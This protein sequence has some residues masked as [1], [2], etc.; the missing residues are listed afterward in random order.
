M[1]YWAVQILGRKGGDDSEGYELHLTATS[2]PTRELAIERM[3]LELKETKRDLMA[4]GNGSWNFI[5]E[6]REVAVEAH[7]LIIE[8]NE[9][10][11]HA[12]FSFARKEDCGDA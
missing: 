9:A 7:N 2:A 4:Q 12:G 5:F 6:V 1:K 8:L 11:G 10:L 3:T